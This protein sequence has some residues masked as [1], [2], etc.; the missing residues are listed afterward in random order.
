MVCLDIGR[1]RRCVAHR[2]RSLSAVE[3]PGVVTVWRGAAVSVAAVDVGDGERQ[4]RDSAV[5]PD[6]GE[7]GMVDERPDVAGTAEGQDAET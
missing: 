3:R 2:G 6:V 5:G 4:E 1:S 7:G